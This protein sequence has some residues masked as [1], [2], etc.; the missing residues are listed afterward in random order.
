MNTPPP[1]R[2]DAI[3][4]TLADDGAPVAEHLR[5]AAETFRLCAQQERSKQLVSL[6][7]E[8][9][10]RDAAS[11]DDT[12]ETIDLARQALVLLKHRIEREAE[13]RREADRQV[14]CLPAVQSA[15]DGA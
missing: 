9:A 8:K 1:D 5:A 10:R 3:I 7:G 12:R 11:E 15:D 14:Q 13:A 2:V 6:Y 4:A